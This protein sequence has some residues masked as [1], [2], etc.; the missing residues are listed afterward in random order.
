MAIDFEA[1]KA[2]AKKK[3]EATESVARA[4]FAKAKQTVTVPQTKATPLMAALSTG[5]TDNVKTNSGTAY[6]PL[7]VPTSAQKMANLGINFKPTAQSQINTIN[8][9]S[10]K[11]ITPTPMV[12]DKQTDTDVERGF[13]A[14]GGALAGDNANTVLGGLRYDLARG[15][16]GVIG[17]GA[18]LVTQASG[19]VNQGLS[20]LTS[21]GG[22]APNAVSRWFDEGAK[23]ALDRDVSG[24]MSAG[25]ENSVEGKKNWPSNI[26]GNLYE[27]VGNIMTG[28]AA[29]GAI[30]GF[31]KLAPEVASK[32]A[33]GLSAGGQGATNAYNE[34]ATP[35]QAISFGNA[36]AG[37]EMAT[38][39]MFGGVPGLGKGVFDDIIKGLKSS[40][41]ALKALV[42]MVGEGGEE[43]LSS[44]LTPYLQRILYN[45]E[46]KNATINELLT[47][48]A[49]GAGLS[50][51][52]Q[53]PSVIGSIGAK[54]SVSS[55]NT[56]YT[57]QTGANNVQK[58]TLTPNLNANIPNVNVQNNVSVPNTVQ[59]AGQITPNIVKPTQ[60]TPQQAA[61]ATT[62]DVAPKLVQ[63]PSQTVNAP[64]T[65]NNASEAKLDILSQ[66]KTEVNSNSK[67]Q[68][69]VS[70]LSDGG[71]T[72][73]PF[74]YNVYGDKIK[75]GEGQYA[76]YKVSDGDKSYIIQIQGYTAGAYGKLMQV[77]IAEPDFWRNGAIATNTLSTL[78]E[79]SSW[80]NEVIDY[81]KSKAEPSTPAFPENS[82]GANVT[83]GMPQGTGAATQGFVPSTPYSVWSNNTEN[84]Q[85]HNVGENS[86]RSVDLP[87]V[88]PQ[89]ERTMKTAATVMESQNTP[90]ARV[91]E[92]QSSMVDGKMAYVPIANK[93]VAQK[94]SEKIERDGWQIALNDWTSNVRNGKVSPDLVAEGATL[95]NNA[96]NA[97]ECTKEAYINLLT[98]YANLVHS[99]GQALQAA[100]IL[101]T[102]TPESRLY[103]MQRSVQSMVDEYTSKNKGK[104][105][106]IKIDA[107]LAEKYRNATTDEERDNVISEIQQDIADQ[108]PSTML[109]KWTALRYVNML[110]NFKTQIRNVAGNATMMGVTKL[111]SEVASGLEHL[112]SA[113][114]G[115]KFE[116]TKSFGVSK[117]LYSAAYADFKNVQK[118]ALGEGKYSESNSTSD[119]ERGINEKRTIFKVNGEWGTK[120]SSPVIAKGARSVTD[121]GMKVLEGYRKI[122]NQAMEIGDVVFSRIT[123][124]DALAGYLKAHNVTAKQVNSGNVD[125]ALMDKARLYAIKEAQEATFRDE[126]AFSKAVS[127]FDSKWSKGGKIISKGI[128]PFR[129]TPANLA[130]RAEEYSP[131][132]LINTVVKGVQVAKGAENVSGADVVNSLAKTLTGS[133]I[134]MLGWALRSAGLLFGEEDDE[135][136]KAFDTLTGRQDYSIVLPNGTSFTVD[137]LTPA[138]MPLFVGATL[139]DLAAENGLKSN[140]VESAITSVTDP[141][142]Q[143]SM[144]AGVNDALSNVKYSDNNLMQFALSSA[145]NYLTQGVT[146]TLLGQ[147]ERTAEKNRMSTYTDPTSLVPSWMQ[148][149]GGK[150]SAKTPGID[151]NQGEY[152][153][154]WGR[155]QNNG[156]TT[157]K[158]ANNFLNPAYVSTINETALEKELQR[159][160]DV[161]G[162][163]SVVPQRI[164]DKS[165]K[166]VD[167]EYSMTPSEQVQFQKTRGQYAYKELNTLTKSSEYKSMT[168]EDKVKAVSDIYSAATLNAK[169]TVV[170]ARGE[171]FVPS[172]DAG[173]KIEKYQSAGIS[174]K[175][176]YDFYK[177]V[178]ALEPIDGEKEVST[179]QKV[180]TIGQQ[181]YTD[182]QAIALV[183]TLYTSSDKT[184]MLPYLTTSKHL[185]SLYLTNR[186]SEMISMTIP[187]KVTAKSVEYEL[188]DK[189]KEVFK[190]TYAN[191]FNS[192]VTNLTTAAQVKSLRDKAFDAAK[193]AVIN[194]R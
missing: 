103:A 158:I 96:G 33:M 117:E 26:T 7:T 84:G 163:S 83:K 15:L 125:V 85:F 82:L 29:G 189:E 78:D 151:Y 161:T 55:S 25:I 30:S 60:N 2:K 140:D 159:L 167:G 182:T 139:Y 180:Q 192:R 17:G 39:S 175:Q 6:K 71:K 185:L 74:D 80:V 40:P 36:V 135:N 174:Q 54:P 58:Q 69:F 92:I 72:V 43:V 35:Q 154:A 67:E 42:D 184:S 99:S 22:T 64:K 157:G 115:G 126:N 123:Y 62:S 3:D 5:K 181:G 18:G 145:A 63:V 133:G 21:L 112:V 168:D 45:P 27:T 110:G 136:Q 170:E 65:Q 146:N 177:T 10:N 106:E 176:A 31:T 97:K 88:N 127:N 132:G 8:G 38:E 124:A 129:K 77:R 149:I 138:S 172:V 81:E 87:K 164:T 120:D 59:N 108:V 101:K 1:L 107:D 128:L 162:E 156:A 187:S 34:G 50:G 111:K 94:A 193:S 11:T 68:K 171:M 41:T 12:Q 153:D 49:Y 102:L 152:V 79:V 144:M 56:Q 76:S 178:E 134:L 166:G 47:S 105:V 137:W 32:L 142:V 16:G 73:E 53:A 131:L 57:A 9:I 122:T 113:V 148:R 86:A 121:V 160:Y 173:N 19:L 51:L 61:Q 116:R 37:L 90:D 20:A 28:K 98:D 93:S 183:G 141:I 13:Y 66:P 130:V 44:F 119:F 169:Q 46:A 95:L 143:M 147:V 190:T 155:T 70:S 23:Y 104:T 52:M 4:D 191:Y 48:F 150:A 89:G 75:N 118:A 14:L 100:R 194:G 114:S 91:E 165:F 109:D 188:T 186:D 24:A 179:Y